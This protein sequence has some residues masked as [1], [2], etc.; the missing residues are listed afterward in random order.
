MVGVFLSHSAADKPFARRLGNALR[1]YGARV[2]IDEAEIKVGESLLDKISLA[3]LDADFLVVVLS[4]ASC[5]SEWVRREVNL[6][7]TKEIQGKVVRVLPCLL[8]E[9]EIPAFLVEKKY[10][11]FRSQ[12]QFRST[13]VELAR[14]LGL[15]QESEKLQFLDQHVFYGLTDLNDGFDAPEAQYFGASD[16]AVVL[17]RVQYFG[18]GIYGIEPWPDGEFGDVLVCEQF[19]MDPADPLWYRAAFDQF[20][21]DRIDSHFSAT[22]DVQEALLNMFSGADFDRPGYQE[23][24]IEFPPDIDAWSEERIW[25]FFETDVLPEAWNRAHKDYIAHGTHE[26]IRER[27]LERAGE[28]A[29]DYGL[30]EVWNRFLEQRRK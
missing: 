3:I 26:D 7:L 20:L 29:V 19:S 2:W 14:S 23:K 16:F 6:A 27:S 30:G 5:K 9:C 11:D 22:Y 28:A 18:L 10:A 13:A 24:G 12:E 25:R 4:R 21:N 15:S 17:K 1:G 8:E